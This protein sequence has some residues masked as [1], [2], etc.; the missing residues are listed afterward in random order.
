MKDVNSD[1]NPNSN[2][3]KALEDHVGTRFSST[4][5][6]VKFAVLLAAILGQLSWQDPSHA[7]LRPT[8]LNSRMSERLPK[9]CLIVDTRSLRFAL[10]FTSFGK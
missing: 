9:F 10:H 2:S 8:A 4:I 5:P 6:K 3:C 1:Y 7:I